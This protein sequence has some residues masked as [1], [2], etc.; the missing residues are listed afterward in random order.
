VECV[1]EAHNLQTFINHQ[2]NGH[3]GYSSY[4]YILHTI[5]IMVDNKDLTET[6]QNNTGRTAWQVF[7]NYYTENNGN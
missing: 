5:I 6:V 3:I 7:T 2:L 4:I 1:H